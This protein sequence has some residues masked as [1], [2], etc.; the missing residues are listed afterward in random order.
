VNAADRR[1]LVVLR[2]I[3]EKHRPELLALVASIGTEPLTEDSRDTLRIVVADELVDTGLD[4]RHEHNQ[5]GRM[6][7]DL[8]DW[9]G[10][11]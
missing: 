4:E 1:T 7:E 11:V 8:I 2:E 9:L 10:H 6:L 3:V 5:R